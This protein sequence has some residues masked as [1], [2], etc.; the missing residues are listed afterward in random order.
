M[1]RLQVRFVVMLAW[2]SVASGARAQDAALAEPQL[3]A[4][5]ARYLADLEGPS[6]GHTRGLTIWRAPS[7]PGGVLLPT[8]Y[9]ADGERGVYLAA[10]HLRPAIEAGL[11]PP[12]QIIGMD[13]DPAHRREEYAEPGRARFR[14]HERWVLDVVIPWAERVARASPE[15]RAIGGFSNGGDFA[16]AMGARHPDIFSAVLAQSPVSTQTFRLDARAANVRWALSAGRI[17]MNGYAAAAVSTVAASVA[18]QGG[19]LRR[20]S[21]TWGHD[22]ASWVDLTPGAVAWLFG[23]PSERVSTQLERNSCEV[24]GR[25]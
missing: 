5:E 12:I 22:Y 15:H 7:T 4:S 2:L 19:V 18:D 17:E 8:L 16:I 1:Q 13:P 23:F 24:F 21:G 11:I 9:M 3:I 6:A 25:R 10:A 20:C 14:A